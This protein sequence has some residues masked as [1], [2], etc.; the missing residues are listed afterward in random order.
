[1]ERRELKADMCITFL[2]AYLSSPSLERALK[3]V[4]YGFLLPS[5]T[6][7]DAESIFADAEADLRDANSKRQIAQEWYLAHPRLV[8]LL[9]IIVR[10]SSSKFIRQSISYFYYWR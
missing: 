3:M 9:R 6:E 7:H 4:L 1:N 8:E 2:E 5:F 10:L